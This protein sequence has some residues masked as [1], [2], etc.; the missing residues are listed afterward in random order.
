MY[1]YL[2]NGSRFAVD[3]FFSAETE[4]GMLDVMKFD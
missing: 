2:N 3:Y 1:L 4:N